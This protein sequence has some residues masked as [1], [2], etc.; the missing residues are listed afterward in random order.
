MQPY[1]PASTT[2]TM[3]P[4]R[5]NHALHL[6]LFLITFGLWTPVWIVVAAINSGRQVPQA[7]T[8]VQQPAPYHYPIQYAQGQYPP[9][10]Q[11]PPSQ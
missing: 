11:L 6:I 4:A 7:Q 3:V 2:V 10:Q 5:T 1:Q 8:F 9:P